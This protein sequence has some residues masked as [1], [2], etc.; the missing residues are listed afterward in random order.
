M[1]RQRETKET[2]ETVETS[3]DTCKYNMCANETRLKRLRRQWRHIMV[4]SILYTIYNT[5]D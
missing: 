3:G 2:R 5:R 4:I 1:E